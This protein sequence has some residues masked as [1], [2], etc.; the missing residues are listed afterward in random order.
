MNPYARMTA[1]LAGQPVDR[2]PNF[3]IFMQFAAHTSHNNPAILALIGKNIRVQ[4]RHHHLGGSRAKVLLS[5]TDL[6]GLPQPANFPLCSLK[7][8]QVNGLHRHAL[9]NGV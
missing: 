2:A 6:V 8:V 5:H 7:D 4:L 3:N 9:L 1:R